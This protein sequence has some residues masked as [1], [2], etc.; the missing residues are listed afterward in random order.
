MTTALDI[1]LLDSD[2]VR[3]A[4]KMLL[5][6]ALRDQASCITLRYDKAEQ[7]SHVFFDGREHVP[8]PRDLF[9]D[10]AAFF[11]RI[12]RMVA[13]N[14]DSLMRVTYSE[15]AI[16]KVREVHLVQGLNLE[17]E[18]ATTIEQLT[19][20]YERARSRHEQ[21]RRRARSTYYQVLLLI[22]FCFIASGVLLYTWFL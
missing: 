21:K 4:C 14:P 10:I 16:E 6:L 3:R 7:L 5:A 19:A 12:G 11:R 18:V 22:V 17:K 13:K 9:I 1:A 8:P 20:R 2:P 15:C